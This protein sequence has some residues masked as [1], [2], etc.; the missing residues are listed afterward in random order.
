MNAPRR[1]FHAKVKRSICIALAIFG[2]WNPLSAQTP[3][4]NIPG[5]ETIQDE[6][7]VYGNTFN[8]GTWANDITQLGL[9]T[10]YSEDTSH[11]ATLTFTANRPVSN[12]LWQEMPSTGTSKVFQ[13]SLSANNAFTLYDKATSQSA[14]IILDPVTR[15]TFTTPVTFNGLDNK[16]PNQTPNDPTNVLTVGL[17]DA[18]YPVH[19][20]GDTL[21][22]GVNANA[23]GAHAMALGYQ[24]NAS[25]FAS[26]VLG[27]YATATQNGSTAL[28]LSSSATGNYSTALGYAS[29]AN[30][31]WATATGVASSAAGDD[32]IAIGTYANAI[33]IGSCAL[34]VQTTATGLGS[35]AIGQYILSAGMY[36]TVVGYFNTASGDQ[37][38]AFGTNAKATAFQSTSLGFQSAA[39][40]TGAV[41]AGLNS[42]AKGNW[43]VALGS[44]SNAGG[45][46]ATALTSSSA[47]SGDY[48][49]AAG[50]TTATSLYQTSVG[51]YGASGGDP[52]N[53]VPTDDLFTVGNGTSANASNAFSVKKNGDTQVAGNLTVTKAL[54]VLPQGDLSMGTF[55]A[56]P[57]PT[58]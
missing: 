23:T 22:L 37:A 45:D 12:W 31:Y 36:T 1:F 15:S 30:G 28:G 38:S 56:Q 35:T 16:M 18:R 10:V 52:H 34:G 42:S 55:M 6:L 4:T 54:I 53:W 57:S 48:A 41:S 19:S 20:V 8:L 3:T 44:F 24:A 9:A 40:G 58:P 49:V 43:S 29:S 46:Y 27:D 7:D 39:A 51:A 47:A 13:M 26:T 14:A 17:A 50:R 21:T 2:A 5:N 32:S 11:M 25:G 33:G